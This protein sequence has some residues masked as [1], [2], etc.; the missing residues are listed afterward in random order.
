LPSAA[1]APEE[2]VD[3]TLRLLLVTRHEELESELRGLHF[4]LCHVNPRAKFELGNIVKLMLPLHYAEL[5]KS[6]V[7]DFVVHWQAA[8]V[9]S[10]HGIDEPIL[11]GSDTDS[12]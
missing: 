2:A 4:L 7:E 10:N 6:P 11:E 5:M 3:N 8:V 12:W 9:P 1:G